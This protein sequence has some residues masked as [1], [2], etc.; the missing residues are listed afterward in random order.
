MLSSMEARKFDGVVPWLDWA[1]VTQC[2]IYCNNVIANFI[3]AM[4]VPKNLQ[5]Q[6]TPSHS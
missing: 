1:P 3:G 2:M 6:N 5:M 4:V